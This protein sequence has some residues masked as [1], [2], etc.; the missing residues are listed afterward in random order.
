MALGIFLARE[1]VHVVQLEAPRVQKGGHGS[2][3]LARARMFK[4]LWPKKTDG[5]SV[6]IVDY[7]TMKA[8]SFA[9]NRNAPASVTTPHF[10]VRHQKRHSRK[11]APERAAIEHVGS[12]CHQRRLDHHWG[13]NPGASL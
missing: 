4:E 11:N 7:S 13:P 9:P 1:G 10:K 3:E 2:D 8:I 6:D 5:A 12:G